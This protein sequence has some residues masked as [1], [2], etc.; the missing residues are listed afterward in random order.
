MQPTKP[1]G[2]VSLLLTIV[3]FWA[4]YALSY[5][6]ESKVALSFGGLY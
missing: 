2:A 5:N 3:E 1:P 4:N 6:Q